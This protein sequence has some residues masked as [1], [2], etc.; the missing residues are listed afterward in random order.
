MMRYAAQQ[1]RYLTLRNH[2][3]FHKIGILYTLMIDCINII[4]LDNFSI[5][6][7]I[8]FCPSYPQDI[9]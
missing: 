6:Y 9:L 7:F 8:F 5:M 3:D 1:S 4:K 2:G